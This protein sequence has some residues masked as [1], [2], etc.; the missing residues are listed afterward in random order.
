MKDFIKQQEEQLNNL[1]EALQEA[2]VN[3]DNL[4]EENARLQQ[5]YDQLQSSQQTLQK[6][7]ES[8][9][10]VSESIAGT[11]KQLLGTTK[12]IAGAATAFF[13]L[14]ALTEDY[15]ENQAKL[16]T[17]YQAAGMSV[18]AAKDAYAGF[19]KI[20]GDNDTA[21]EASQLLAKLVRNE[22]DISKWTDIAAGVYGT[23]G[24]A[25]P[26]EALIESANETSRTGQ[27]TGNLADAINWATK[28]GETFGVKLKA[29]TKANEEW[30]KAVKACQTAEDYFNLA[31][32]ACGT[33]AERNKLIMDTLQGSYADA[34]N[35]FYQNN[36]QLI[37]SR[38]SQILYNN[39]L[40]DL[41]RIAGTAKTALM[42]LLGV[43]ADGSVKANSALSKVQETLS[44]L[45][46][47][48][49]LVKTITKAAAALAA[50]TVGGLATKLGFLE[51]KKG[52]L[53]VQAVFTKFKALKAAESLG[54]IATNAGGAATKL[55]AIAAKVGPIMGIV[56]VV[57]AIAAAIYYVANNL[58]DVRA[59]IQQTFG[60]EGLKIFD[61]IWGAI[62]MVGDALKTAF[63]G[64]STELFATLQQILPTIVSTLQ[65]AATNILPVITQLITQLAPLLAQL[66]TA[67]LPVLGQLISAIITVAG[68]L[69]TAVLPVIVDLLAQLIPAITQIIT[70][71]LPVIIELINTLLP[72]V[73][74]IIQAVLPVIIE[75]LNTL[76][77]IVTQIIQAILPIIIELLN[78]IVPIIQLIINSILPILIQ[79]INTLL[80]L[81]QTIISAILPVLTELMNALVPVIQVL[82]SV[83]SSVLGSALTTITNIVQNVMTVFQGLIDFIT[84]VFSGNWSQAWEGIKSI[85]SGAV[86]GLGEIIKAPISAVVSVVNGVIS[87]LNKLKVPDWVP[88]LGGKGINIPLIPGFA[89]GTLSTPDTFIA[90][91]KGPELITNA[92]GRTVFTAEQTRQILGS[93]NAAANTAATVA[94]AKTPQT[95]ATAAPQ[96]VNNYQTAPEVVS[97]AGSGGGSSKHITINN[98]PTIVV[99][100][101]KPEDLDA[102]LQENNQRLLQQVEELM[103]EKED[104]ERRQR[105]D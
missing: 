61:Q 98:N 80:P 84:G 44:K 82:S 2:G 26:I 12:V 51:V 19:Y 8:Q 76:V 81:F 46:N 102:K 77:P 38:Q 52:V 17:A 72:L 11:K 9:Q 50:L 55:G 66:V 16:N 21:T 87:G 79:A 85:F 23:F 73:M 30:N 93:Q 28:E 41:G 34:T 71:I 59:K 56:A 91:E 32:Q 36:Q 78:Q 89:K 60:D 69:I 92:P 67:L 64:V 31:L 75:L 42:E 3:T 83:L 100:G 27:V 15:R 7:N 4:T 24:D 29:N 6:I 94:A 25:L 20:L 88:G 54:S 39:M 65:M 57:A 5:S 86:G 48:P 68:Q 37:Q 47:N 97:G 96:M 104:K 90:G 45:A 18:N 53:G 58:E 63:A 62:T 105:Y 35:A 49:E 95:Q 33:E 13:A 14:D 70:A 1:A 74:Q 10:K 40:A 101:E 103:D 99:E 43:S 22:Q